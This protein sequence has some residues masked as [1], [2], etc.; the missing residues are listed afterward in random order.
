M[1]A[2][3][4]DPYKRE[5]TEVETDGSNASM[6]AHLQ[7]DMFQIVYLRKEDSLY[8]DEEFLINGSILDLAWFSMPD[9]HQD[10]IGSRGIIFGTDQEGRNISP[11]MTL[12]EVRKAVVW[13][14]LDIAKRQVVPV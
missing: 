1:K 6:Y 13:C 3:V 10:P 4:I 12:D 9:F 8:V 14:R 11:L 7:C 2:I 5:I